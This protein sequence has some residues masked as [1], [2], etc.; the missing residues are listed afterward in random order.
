MELLK[1][2]TEAFG[3]PSFEAEIRDICRR[4]LEPLVDRYRAYKDVLSQIDDAQALL[5]D[6]DADMVELA[7][8]ELEEL[9]PRSEALQDA[10]RR[11]LV[12]KDPRDDKN[13][14]IEIAIEPLARCHFDEA[15]QHIGGNAVM[16][17][18]A[19]LILEGN[20]TQLFNH[21]RQILAAN[22]IGFAIH[23]IHGRVAKNTISQTG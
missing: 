10:L 21:F 1:E 12:P 5:E 20:F 14:L 23:L 6:D 15:S 4:E 11:M 19:R 13:V 7:Q 8:A 3:P 22:N 18:G 17:F 9:T 16:P 2:L